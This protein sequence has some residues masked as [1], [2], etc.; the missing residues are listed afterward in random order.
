M[1][2]ATPKSV[3]QWFQEGVS[4][5]EINARI[6]ADRIT[7]EELK[8]W[9]ECSATPPPSVAPSLIDQMAQDIA[10][11]F[12]VPWPDAIID[13]RAK[14][15]QI[16]RYYARQLQGAL[17]RWAEL[18]DR[19]N[20]SDGPTPHPYEVLQEKLMVFS[21]GAHLPHPD[22]AK[23]G[24]P[25]EKWVRWGNKLAKLLKSRLMNAGF[26]GRTNPEDPESV[27]AYVGAAAI[28]RMY[29]MELTAEGFASAMR[30]RDRRKLTSQ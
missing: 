25:R 22:K 13:E 3:G 1:F 30:N 19:Q 18:R 8:E 24:R 6:E 15:D 20:V 16:V 23:R 7:S 27:V 2:R 9:L 14:R 10:Y 12:E 29:E 11:L 28:S 26:N 4:W 21:E 5:E 17:E